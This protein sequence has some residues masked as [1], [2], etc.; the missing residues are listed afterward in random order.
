MNYSDLITLILTQL[1]DRV[2]S[3]QFLEQFRRA[4]SFVRHHKLTLKQV[5]AYLIYS[6][7]LRAPDTQGF[8]ARTNGSFYPAAQ[9]THDKGRSPWQQLRPRGRLF[10]GFDKLVHC[11]MLSPLGQSFLW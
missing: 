5:V 10:V 3:N 1:R 2:N 4:K 8:S 9:S 11:L 7:N 6:K